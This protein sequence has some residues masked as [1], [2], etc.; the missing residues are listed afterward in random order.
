MNEP[1]HE[2][3]TDRLR[4]AG[5]IPYRVID[6]GVEV[7][8]ITSRDTGRWIVP[9]GY[10]KKSESAEET[11]LHEAFEE[12]GVEGKIVGPGPAGFIHYDKTLKQ[13]VAKEACIEMYFLQVTKT[14]KK[15]PEKGHR[16]V[17]WFSPADASAMVS[18]PD[19]AKLLLQ[20]TE[21][22]LPDQS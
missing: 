6:G 17:G 12:A 18:D 9:K 7:L 14:R 19:L 16:I 3:C 2:D 22:H 21:G 15:W 4:Q 10:V 11:A 13:D 8:L 20:L 5:A 1:T